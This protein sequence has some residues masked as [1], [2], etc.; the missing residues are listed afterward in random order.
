MNGRAGHCADIAD[1]VF[2]TRAVAAS[3]KPV[4]L[5][6]LASKAPAEVTGLDPADWAAFNSFRALLDSL[7][8]EPL[9]VRWEAG[10]VL[11][12]TRH[13]SPE[14]SSNPSKLIANAA[15][16]LAA[17]GKLVRDEV[18]TAKRPVPCGRLAQ[19]IIDR[20]GA[21]AADWGGKATFRRFLEALDLG[22]LRI[23]WSVAGGYVTDP[24]FPS[25]AAGGPTQSARPD[26][27]SDSDLLP[28]MNLVHAATG[29][30]LLSPTELHAVLASLSADLEG[31]PFQL[32]ETGKRVRDR[33][34]DAGYAISRADVSFVLKGIVLGGHPFGEGADAPESLA[35]RFIDSVLELSR[36]EQLPLEELQVAEVREWG[37]RSTAARTSGA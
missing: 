21:T 25:V 33:C 11:D 20:H 24:S 16:S 37:S 9:L 6:W 30:P 26:W 17:V 3:P 10:V 7:K 22:P 4:A 31:Q 19:L 36:R 35:Q 8:L 2:I 23:D 12:P 5:P 15:N 34:R 28:V 18:A 14:R 27:G 13:D 29:M 1:S 32:A